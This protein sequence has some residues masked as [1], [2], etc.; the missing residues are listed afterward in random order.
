MSFGDD[1]SNEFLN[2][3]KNI[4]SNEVSLF[5]KLQDAFINLSNYYSN[6]YE[7]NIIHGNKSFVEF[8]FN[9]SWVF[10]IAF[11]SKMTKEL[12]DMM[13][14]V[15]SEKKNE[16]RITYMQNKKGNSSNKFFADLGQ[17]HLLS[18]RE[19][20]LSIPLPSCLFGDKLFLFNAT[21][22][23]VGSYGIFYL[24][25]RNIEMSYFPADL[26]TP[27]NSSKKS[28]TRLVEYN[29]KNFNQTRRNGNDEES[30]GEE[31]L[32]QFGDKLI[33]MKIGTPVK[34]D[35][36][37][38]NQIINFLLK[39]F[40][41]MKF[42]KWIEEY[43]IEDDNSNNDNLIYYVPNICVINADFYENDVKSNKKA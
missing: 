21:L 32:K 11:G 3:T 22:Q 17:L 38:Y 16:I 28:M 24:D 27:I 31:T 4:F 35:D 26:I 10:S 13:F 8:K 5:T 19:E 12:A 34:P 39:Y 9:S 18:A 23:S 29:T 37:S 43:R 36:N 40:P 41:D 42:T 33:G 6:K 15:F 7:I 14:I 25:N 20:I 2:L 30:T 1:L